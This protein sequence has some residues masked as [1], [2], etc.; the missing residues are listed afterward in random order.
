VLQLQRLLSLLVLQHPNLALQQL[1]PKLVL[2]LQL[3]L[4]LLVLQLLLL[5]LL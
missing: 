2:V 5:Q 3:L 1:L 4:L